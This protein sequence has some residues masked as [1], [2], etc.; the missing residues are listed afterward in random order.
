[1]SLLPPPEA[2]T[3]ADAY[4]LYGQAGRLLPKE[5]VDRMGQGW[6]R[7][8]P[9]ELPLDQVREVLQQ[10]GPA[11]DVVEKASLCRS[12][13]WP[14]AQAGVLPELTPYR[15]FSRLLHIKAALAMAENRPADAVK[16][17]QT[18][19]AMARH[20][21][22]GPGL[23]PPMVGV[24]VVS[25]TCR[26][27]PAY[28]EL[29]GAQSLYEAIAGL[30]KPFIDVERQCK[31]EIDALDTNP[32]VNALNRGAF[33]EQLKGA[34]DQVRQLVKRMER[35]IAAVQCLEAIRLYAAENKG[36]LPAA[37]DQI[38]VPIPQDPLNGRA[39][40]YTCTSNQAV[41]SSPA[42]E[43]EAARVALRYEITAAQTELGVRFAVKAVEAR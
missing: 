21:G 35:D 37:L 18:N 16:A 24:A 7:M 27:I 10:C 3:D 15:H 20:L 29:P 4:P 39:F 41:L 33:L 32:Q 25:L 9:N 5:A 11:L 22:T 38:K 23:M 31:A 2:L 8:R 34:H 14:A 17:L 36:A 19:F 6:T 43:G 1:L 40:E 28:L 26:S 42:P 30:P 12:C 13:N